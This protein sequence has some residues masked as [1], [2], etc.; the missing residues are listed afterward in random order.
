MDVS[1]CVGKSVEDAGR[2]VDVDHVWRL[3]VNHGECHAEEN[4]RALIKEQ[5]PD[6]KQHAHV[7]DAREGGQEPVQADEGQLCNSASK[8]VLCE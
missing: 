2:V 1:R 5:V 4:D 6:A 3:H 7:H 8:F